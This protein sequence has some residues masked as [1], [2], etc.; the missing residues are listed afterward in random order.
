[1]ILGT[2]YNITVDPPGTTDTALITF[3][4]VLCSI[5][6]LVLLYAWIH[7]NYHPIRAKRLTMTTIM[8][9]IAILWFFGELPNNGHIERVGLWANCRLWF[10]WF[11]FLF[12]HLFF[13]TVLLRFYA[14]DRI[15]N[16]RKPFRG[17][18]V[19]FINVAVTLFYVGLCMAAQHIKEIYV[20]SFDPNTKACR[21]TKP[22]IYSFL[23]LGLALW[24]ALL[25]LIIR[26]RSINS[27]FNEF[28][29]SLIIFVIS[30]ALLAE[31]AA[32]NALHPMFPLQ[33][34]YR[35][36]TTFFD[37]AAANTITL[38]V[39][40]YPVYKCIFHRKE[41][42]IEWRAKLNRD[43]LEK[44]YEMT[45]AGNSNE[46]E[47]RTKTNAELVDQLYRHNSYSLS[48]LSSERVFIP[49]NSIYRGIGAQPGAN[50]HSQQSFTIPMDQ[51]LHFGGRTIL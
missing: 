51:D 15:F 23:G 28:R 1:M 32:I 29:E 34:T 6:T 41:Y 22:V 12:S 17:R 26:L 36:I 21:V 30:A 5:T 46:T 31:I 4:S 25:I 9:L 35:F 48:S 49:A 11:R 2:E 50:Q 18:I 19:V 8:H 45:R 24:V 42:E 16:Q 37:V 27:S 13:V 40:V 43:Q 47:L 38:L 7:R 10:I 3:G 14:L 44:E 33:K 39:L 20:V